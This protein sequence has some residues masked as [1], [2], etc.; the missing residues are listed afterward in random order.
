MS[1]TFNIALNYALKAKLEESQ[2]APPRFEPGF[3]SAYWTDT[4]LAHIGVLPIH[5]GANA[6]SSPTYLDVLA[7]HTTRAGPSDHKLLWE[8]HYTS[9]QTTKLANPLSGG[10]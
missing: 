9:S 6:T 7:T 8:V 4:I 1:L 10:D 5:S 2:A 3:S